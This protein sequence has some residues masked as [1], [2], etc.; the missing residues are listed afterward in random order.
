MDQTVR[1]QLSPSW[2]LPLQAAS[3][4]WAL[5]G[6]RQPRPGKSRGKPAQRY[7]VTQVSVSLPGQGKT[8]CGQWL[9]GQPQRS[10]PSPG[11]VQEQEVA[12]WVAFL[13][14]RSVCPRCRKCLGLWSLLSKTPDAQPTGCPDAQGPQKECAELKQAAS[15]GQ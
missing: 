14:P 5:C 12:P 4:L 8:A 15:A 3:D 6:D 11:R 7:A 2:R 10:Q 13:T 9:D 1:G